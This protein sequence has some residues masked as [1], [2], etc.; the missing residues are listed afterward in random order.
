M[1]LVARKYQQYTNL[2]LTDE[3]IDA[4]LNS[5][6]D[7]FEKQLKVDFPKFDA[8]PESAMLGILD[9]AFNLGNS[10]LVNKFPS[11][12]AAALNEDWSSCE[13][14][15]NRRGISDSRN[16][17]VKNLFRECLVDET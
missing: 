15:C 4:L 6:I 11:F 14:E 3:A 9:M 12:T 7:G 16:T 10:G 13:R 5:R 2:I 8:Y 1:G 17:E